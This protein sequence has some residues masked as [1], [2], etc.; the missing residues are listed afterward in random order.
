MNFYL[1][2][3]ASDKFNFSV[4]AVT[5][6]VTASVSLLVFADVK[7]ILYK[8]LFRFLRSVKITFSNVGTGNNQFAESARRK[9]MSESIH[10]IAL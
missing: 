2:V 6:N 3:T 1:T 7:R 4:Q 9:E 8:N 10:N 5:D